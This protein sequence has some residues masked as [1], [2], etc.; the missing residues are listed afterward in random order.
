MTRLF[1]SVLLSL[2]VPL[3][4]GAAADGGFDLQQLMHRL[5]LVPRT[6]AYFSE[7]KDVALVTEPLNSSGTLSYVAPNKLQKSTLLPKPERYT[8]DGD[9][10]TI[11]RSGEPER[12]VSLSDHPELGAF[13]D[14]V[15][16][17]LA[18]DLPAL[19]RHYTVALQG[20]LDAWQLTLEPK[21]RRVRELVKWIH[22][23]GR[24]D[25]IRSIASEE[26]DGDRSSM[27]IVE[28][29]R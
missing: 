25:S 12:T 1:G 28:T 23:A 18:G 2:L 22:I 6:T 16:G 27:T 3:D 10:L 24:G 17:T 15:R 8:V 9:K 26:P 5:S 4:A 19:E 29:G 13:V 21:E 7:H 14:G 11:D 20:S